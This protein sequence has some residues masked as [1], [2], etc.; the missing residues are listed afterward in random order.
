[1]RIVVRAAGM[2]ALI[3]LAACAGSSKDAELAEQAQTQLVGLPKA[4]LLS[5]AG[6]P[7][8]QAVVN[9]TEYYTYSTRPVIETDSP[10]TGVS[11]SGGTSEG[12]GL[13]LGIGVP[14]NTGRTF[15]G[16]D[17]TFVLR[18][19]TVRQLSYPMGA[20]IADCGALVSNCMAQ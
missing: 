18:D 4:A 5:C 1:M 14:L 12:L 2:A 6:V 17:A 16:C 10:G 13:S 3:G 20:S 9:G 7:S 19:G 8:R 15:Q 11:M